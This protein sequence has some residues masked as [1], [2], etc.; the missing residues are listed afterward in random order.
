MFRINFLPTF[1][2]KVNFLGGQGNFLSSLAR[3]KQVLKK[4]LDTCKVTKILQITVK[5]LIIQHFV[6][7]GL[8]M[9]MTP[10]IILLLEGRCNCQFPNSDDLILRHNKKS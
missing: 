8:Y 6:Y 2:G 3:G 10:I 7:E 9:H 4:N 1:I 5:C